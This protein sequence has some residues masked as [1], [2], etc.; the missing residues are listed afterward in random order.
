MSTD[1]RAVWGHHCDE[2][3]CV[4][5][6]RNRVRVGYVLLREHFV[7]IQPLATTEHPTLTTA[8]LA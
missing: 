8:I 1:Y 6:F 5:V 4:M 2:G 3:P 7:A